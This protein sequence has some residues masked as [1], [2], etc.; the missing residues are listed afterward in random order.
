MSVA[1]A[2]G[3]G[4]ETNGGKPRAQTPCPP[5][6]APQEQQALLWC[7]RDVWWAWHRVDPQN[8]QE[9]TWWNVVDPWWKT[10]WA[11]M[12]Q[13]EARVRGF[14]A[15]GFESRPGTH[16]EYLLNAVTPS[17]TGF[18][19]A[20]QETSL[21]A[22]LDEECCATARAVAEGLVAAARQNPKL[23]RAQ[24]EDIA[25]F[26]A[27]MTQVIDTLDLEQVPRHALKQKK[28]QE[29]EPPP[30]CDFIFAISNFGAFKTP[31]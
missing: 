19:Q 2:R 23:T 4:V 11:V 16:L 27:V 7:L 15:D 13:L 25:A 12:Q 31:F 10:W 14:V 6:A 17:L 18:F 26:A 30:V 3:R 1:L 24:G 22:L 29:E 5:F 9:A 21:H 8:L 28:Y 20:C